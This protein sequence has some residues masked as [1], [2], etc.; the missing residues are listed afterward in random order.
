[1]I[2][3]SVLSAC[4]SD[5]SAAQPAADGARSASEDD[6]RVTE[7]PLPA[8]A[9]G[10]DTDF[11]FTLATTASKGKIWSLGTDVAG[12]PKRDI[13]ESARIEGPFQ[14]GARGASTSQGMESAFEVTAIANE[15]AY[16]LTFPLPGRALVIDGS[17]A[18]DSNRTLF[19]RRVRFTGAGGE[20]RRSRTCTWL[21]R[22]APESDN[23]ASAP[24][25]GT[26]NPCGR[27]SS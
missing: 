2:L 17:F 14:L 1:M 9:P 24:G 5:E 8:V 27:R 7:A 15:E 13:V 22:G 25:G 4:S 10:T 26:M 3:G 20:S 6:G 11:S 23:Y 19:T 21:S 18:R 12:W 16:E